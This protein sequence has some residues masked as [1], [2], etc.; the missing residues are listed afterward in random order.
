MEVSTSDL[1]ILIYL[2]RKNIFVIQ[3]VTFLLTIFRNVSEGG[4]AEYFEYLEPF[5]NCSHSVAV[6]HAYQSHVENP[7]ILISRK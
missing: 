7:L 3:S 2:T 6:K 1:R 5:E 4:D